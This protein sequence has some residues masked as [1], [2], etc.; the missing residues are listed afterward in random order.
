MALS[1]QE[2]AAPFVA[3]C[4]ET[5]DRIATDTANGVVARYRRRRRLVDTDLEWVS[6]EHRAVSE[7]PASDDLGDVLRELDDHFED[8]VPLGILAA[9][10]GQQGWTVGD[11]L[12]ATHELRMRGA[13][14]EPRADHLRPV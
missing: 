10:M 5:G 14:W 12:A 9:A 1:I 2:A 4:T 8:G 6:A 11:T 13:L 7:A 3:R